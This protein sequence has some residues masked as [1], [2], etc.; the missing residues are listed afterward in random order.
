MWHFKETCYRK[1]TGLFIIP[2]AV[3]RQITD[4]V[5][6]GNTMKYHNDFQFSWSVGWLPVSL[7]VV[8][9]SQW[10]P[11]NEA[12]AGWLLTTA[13]FIFMPCMYCTSCQLS[14]HAICLSFSEKRNAHTKAFAWIVLWII[15]HVVP[16]IFCK[17]R[18]DTIAAFTLTDCL[19]EDDASRKSLWRRGNRPFGEWTQQASQRL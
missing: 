1:R 15:K 18:R 16:L 4:L 8:D 11:F 7:L 17:G 19:N 5:S 13:H 9:K 6:S 2:L 12:S 10:C 14:T 3:D